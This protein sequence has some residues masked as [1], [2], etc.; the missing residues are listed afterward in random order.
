MYDDRLVDQAQRFVAIESGH[1]HLRRADQHLRGLGEFSSQSRM[2]GHRHRVGERSGRESARRLPMDE[3]GTCGAHGGGQGLSD[4]GVGEGEA[5]PG[6]YEKAAPHP[7][8]EMVQQFGD[9]QAGHGVEQ[10]EVELRARRPP[11]LARRAGCRTGP[12]APFLHRL[13]DALGHVLIGSSRRQLNQEE[14]VSTTP[15]QQILGPIWPDHGDGGLVIQGIE[16]DRRGTRQRR[17]LFGSHRSHEQQRDI[18]QMAGGL[19][20]PSNGGRVGQ[21]Q[22]VDEDHQRL[23]LRLTTQHIPE[24]SEQE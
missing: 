3:G 19:A 8:F 9:G 21:M 15:G 1:C 2:A 11:P 22:I 5:R 14:G 6:L 7:F 17:R 18:D 24:R 10:V 20:Q 13:A 12:I 4:E 23:L 16:D